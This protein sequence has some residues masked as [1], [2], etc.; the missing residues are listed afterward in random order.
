MRHVTPSWFMELFDRTLRPLLCNAQSLVAP[1]VRPGDRVADLG[2]GAG[3]FSVALSR[4]VGATGEVVLVDVQ[5]AML[6]RA[7][8]RCARDRRASARL[9]PVLADGASF[10]PAGHLDFALL[11]WMLHE[12][13]NVA[14]LWHGLAA[15]LA[16]G[17]RALVLEPRWHV[18]REQFE[19]ELAPAVALGLERTDLPPACFSRVALLQA[20]E[21]Y[22]AAGN[23]SS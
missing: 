13:E 8:V 3:Y 23:P 15:A 16:P 18:S 4:L 21:A 6:E 14:G 19:A 1:H 7:Q 11:S 22:V 12:V 10:T 20:P 2:C 5:P 17:G 9:T